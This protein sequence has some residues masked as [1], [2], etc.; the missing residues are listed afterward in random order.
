MIKTQNNKLVGVG[1][2]PA[3]PAEPEL[4]SCQFTGPGGQESGAKGCLSIALPD[5]AVKKDP[6]GLLGL[7]PP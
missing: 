7:F 6:P 3:R 4:D 1:E 2:L 5:A